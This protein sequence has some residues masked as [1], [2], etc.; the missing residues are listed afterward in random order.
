MNKYYKYFIGSG[1]AAL[2]M[3]TVFLLVLTNQVSNTATT[4]NT[5]A[6][7]GEGKVTAKPNIAVIDLAIVTESVSSKDAQNENSKKSKTVVEF[8]KKQNV[9]EKD[10]KTTSY[11]V[12][13]QYKYLQ[14][15]KPEIRGYQVSEKIEF[16]IRELEKVSQILDGVVASGA[17]EISGF[18]FTIDEP[19]KLKSEARE[20]AITDAKEKAKNLKSQLGIKLGKIV[21]FYESSAGVPPIFYAADKAAGGFD[22]NRGPEIPQGENEIVVNVTITYQIK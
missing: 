7:S 6:F 13:P 19:D 16:K 10:I 2:I 12:S 20:K 11:N 17:N 14:Y 3:V 18:Q 22:S 8:L 4:T 15:D 5:V 21:N 1:T 9:Q